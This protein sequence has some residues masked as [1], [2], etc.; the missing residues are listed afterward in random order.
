M[1]FR[2]TI[3][4]FLAAAALICMG[5]CGNNAS[6]SGGS[7]PDSAVSGAGDN[8][9]TDDNED[10]GMNITSTSDLVKQ[11][12]IGWNL[13]NTLDATGGDGVN[14]ETSWGNPK[15]TKAM[16]DDVKAGGF[17]VL[18]VPVTWDKHMD[19]NYN[20]DEAWMNRVQEVVDYGIDNDMFVILNTHHEEWYMPREGDLAEDLAQLEKLWQQIAER[21]KNYGE[22]LLFEGVNEPRL[23]GDGQEWTGTPEARDIVNK[24]AETFVK[25]VRA[26]GGNNEQRALF[27]TPYAASSMGENL[28]ALKIPENAGNIIVSVHAYLPYDFALNTQGMS[29]YKN[30][31]SINGLMKDIKSV[32]L[33][34]GIPV[35]ITEFGCLNKNGNTEERAKCLGDYLTAAENIGVPCVWWDNGAVWSD[36][37]NFGL[38]N[39]QEGGWYFPE[40]IEV[41]NNT[42]GE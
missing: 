15:T 24:Y 17:N 16:I 1:R 8:G 33:D 34:N 28:R 29:R 40:L 7:V 19:E 20:V 37:E 11:M 27:I 21:F 12:R 41:I 36:G 25:T 6:N 13:G 39:R 2:K 26:S 32:F 38:L 5:G 18:R 22:K 9:N 42:I 3:A 31:G 30:D 10:S 23:R 4:A 14:S 35:V